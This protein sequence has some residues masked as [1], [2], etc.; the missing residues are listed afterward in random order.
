MIEYTVHF[1]KGIRIGTRSLRMEHVEAANAQAAIALA[2][3]NFPNY[4]R[5]GYR[6]IRVDHFE[7]FTKA[8]AL[9]IDL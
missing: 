8:R 5:E 4:R 1:Q 9:V 2:K 6:I 7:G 3:Q